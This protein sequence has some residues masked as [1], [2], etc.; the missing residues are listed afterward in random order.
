M[1]VLTV[2]KRSHGCSVR[3]T[4]T[5][6]VQRGL[7]DPANVKV[8]LLLYLP[9]LLLLPPPF[10]LPLLLEKDD[11]SVGPCVDAMLLMLMSCCIQAH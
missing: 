6:L 9:L 3:R 11:Q 7:P 1:V 4:I 5:H 2:C 10:H 8:M